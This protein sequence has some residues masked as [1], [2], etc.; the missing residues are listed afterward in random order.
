MPNVAKWEE[1]IRTN[2]KIFK[3]DLNP[4]VK[5]KKD[6]YLF[7]QHSESNNET[8]Q[9]ILCFHKTKSPITLLMGDTNL[10]C[11]QIGVTKVSRYLCTSFV[12]THL[13]KHHYISK[14]LFLN[15]ATKLML[16]TLTKHCKTIMH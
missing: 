7:I 5:K 12:L 8:I 15:P 3:T 9:F 11:T 10:H 6:T 14:Y 2:K 4:T 13:H 16:A 1:T